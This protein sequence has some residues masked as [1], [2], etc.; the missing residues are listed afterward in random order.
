MWQNEDIWR[1]FAEA[2][3]AQQWRTRS[4]NI[5]RQGRGKGF[6][7]KGKGKD[8]KRPPETCLCCGKEGHRKADCKFTKHV[9]RNLWR[10]RSLGS[11]VSKY[12]H[13]HEVEQNEDEPS[14]DVTAEEVWCMVAREVVEEMITV[15]ALKVSRRVKTRDSL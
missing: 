2:D 5:V 4:A 14:L 13:T 9:M 12:E 15:T 11:N 6:T 7:G 3:I 1:K 10:G 8:K